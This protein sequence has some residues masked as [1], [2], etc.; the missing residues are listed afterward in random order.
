MESLTCEAIDDENCLF[1][2]HVG[3]HFTATTLRAMCMQ[4]LL[5]NLHKH[6]KTEDW[7]RLLNKDMRD[8]LLAT[9]RTWNLC[10]V[11]VSSNSS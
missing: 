10:K 7:T 3:D 2:F 4:R 5:K 1:L 6:I 8:K 9:A 11:D